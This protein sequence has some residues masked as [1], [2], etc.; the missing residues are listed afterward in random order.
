MSLQPVDEDIRTEAKLVNLEKEK[1]WTHQ[2]EEEKRQNK[3]KLASK[4]HS[5]MTFIGIANLQK[6]NP[7]HNRK[8][9]KK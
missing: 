8:G 5:I 7:S 9:D 2:T 4:S 6:Q 3:P 1:K